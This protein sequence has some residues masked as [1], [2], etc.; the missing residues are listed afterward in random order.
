[1]TFVRDERGQ[2]MQMI[3][4]FVS[5]IGFAALFMIFRQFVPTIT[6]KTKAA[7]SNATAESGAA[8]IETLFTNLPFIALLL[9][10]FGLIAYAVFL[11]QGVVR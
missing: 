1:V 4:Y 2:S 9:A 3:R 10:G 11:R 6:G 7:T 5:L 8:G